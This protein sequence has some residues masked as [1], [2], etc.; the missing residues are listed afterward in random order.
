MTTNISGNS[1]FFILSNVYC[2]TKSMVAHLECL[3]ACLEIAASHDRGGIQYANSTLSLQLARSDAKGFQI[4]LKIF[5]SFQKQTSC[6]SFHYRLMFGIFTYQ[7][8]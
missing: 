7:G 8:F 4:N 1:L 5:L 2:L 6:I 3:S